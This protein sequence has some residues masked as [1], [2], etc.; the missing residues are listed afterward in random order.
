MLRFHDTAIATEKQHSLS[1]LIAAKH[2]R[3]FDRNRLKPE[4]DRSIDLSARR[5][6]A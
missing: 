1:N 2:F 5:K 4:G 6:N 3:H